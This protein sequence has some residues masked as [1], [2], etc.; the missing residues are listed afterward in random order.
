MK[1]ALVG[2]AL[3]LVLVGCDDPA[4]ECEEAGGSYEFSH[5]LTMQIWNGKMYTPVNI[6]QYEC[7]MPR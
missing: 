3:S 4:K 1:A 7:E 6:P 2:A 5:F